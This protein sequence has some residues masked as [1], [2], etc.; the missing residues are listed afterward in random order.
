MVC[1]QA[2]DIPFSGEPAMPK[3][4]ICQPS[5]RVVLAQLRPERLIPEFDRAN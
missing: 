3:T 4:G 1:A 2:G 5:F